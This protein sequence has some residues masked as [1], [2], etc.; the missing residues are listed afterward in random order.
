MIVPAVGLGC[1][2]VFGVAYVGIYALMQRI[3]RNRSDSG[4]VQEGALSEKDIEQTALVGG[5]VAVVLL[6]FSLLVL[7][8]GWVIGIWVTLT[9]LGIIGGLLTFLIKSG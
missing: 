9:L 4:Q 1:L 7:P 5:I 6:I 2:V 3:A 8:E